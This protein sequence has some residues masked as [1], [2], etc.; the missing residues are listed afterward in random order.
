MIYCF[1]I[2]GVLADKTSI[3]KLDCTKPEERAEFEKAVPSLPARKNFINLVNK[4]GAVCFLT[5][6]TENLRGRTN[7][8][9]L[10]NGVNV[11]YELFMRPIG[12]TDKC[13]V[14]KV[15][16]LKQIIATWNSIMF[17]DDNPFTCMAVQ[18]QLGK[19]GVSVCEVL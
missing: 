16:M 18:K 15:A 10:E 14:L 13:Q 6:R 9:L 7:K 2:D 5:S 8:W 19:Y 11:E 4:L 17:F 1:D 3:Q 12:N